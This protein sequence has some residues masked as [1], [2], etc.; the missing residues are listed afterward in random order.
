MHRNA[1]LTPAGRLRLCHRIGSGWSVIAA[2]ES[3]NVS[4]QTASKWWGRYLREGLPGLADRSSRPRRSPKHTPGAT[5]RQILR[6]RGDRK[7]GPARIGGILGIPHR[8]CTG[9]WRATGVTVCGGWI[10]PPAV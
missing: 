1:P 6:L 2:A 4:R 8:R 5:E 3:M 9:S 7:L 10:G